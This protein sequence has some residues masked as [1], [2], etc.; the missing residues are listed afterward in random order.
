[1]P[2]RVAAICV[3][4]SESLKKTDTRDVCLLYVCAVVIV[5]VLK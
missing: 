1:M 5:G 4:L 3:S 2:V